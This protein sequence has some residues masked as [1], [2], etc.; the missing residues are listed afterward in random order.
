MRAVFRG[1]CI[2]ASEGE[3]RLVKLKH[4]WRDIAAAPTENAGGFSLGYG[5]S[6]GRNAPG[7]KFGEGMLG[8]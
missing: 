5:A 7:Y 8:R 2:A 3:R 4:G 1:E 6:R